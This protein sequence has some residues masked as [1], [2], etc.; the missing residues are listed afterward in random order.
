MS[1]RQLSLFDG[2]R[3]SLED[4]VEL[5]LASLALYGSRYKRWAVA[6]SGGKDSSATVTFVAWAILNGLVDAPESLT[7]LYADT[8]MELPP[9][10]RTAM[11]LLNTLKAQGFDAQV[12]LPTLDKRFYVYMLGLGVP[13]PKNRFRWCTPMIKVQPM[14]D[15]LK[16][17][18]RESGEKVLMLTG[19]R[20]GESAV[21]DQRIA[22]SCSKDSGECGQGWFQQATDNAIADTLA[23]LLH[24][25]VCH[26]YDWLY[27]EQ[28]RHGYD[29]SAIAA[30]YG[31]EDVR[32]GCAGCNLIEKDTAIE[33]L[34]RMPEWE[35]LRPLLELKPLYREL[36]K[37]KWRKRKHEPEILKD[38][39]YGKNPQRMGPLT[40]GARKFGLENI[41]DIQKRSQVDLINGEEEARIREMWVLDMW[42]NK[43]SAVDGDADLPVDAIRL[44]EETGKLVYQALLV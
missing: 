23:P 31:D 11:E 33:R 27:F 29:V 19:V 44:D 7:V 15:A 9:L 37:A 16:G 32:T 8:R 43:W 24:W 6:Y 5:S 38:G 42:P 4:A 34:V 30:V 40:M 12:V 39:S 18:F 22:L 14:G 41:L 26:I 17:L 1:K 21:R 28:G 20:I 2:A 13:P 36:T 25:R 10:Q 35:H 3:I